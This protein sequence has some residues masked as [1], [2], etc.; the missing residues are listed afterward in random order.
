M[1][2]RAPRVADFER[3]A[4]FYG[5]DRARFVGGPLTPERAWRQLAAEAGHW[6]LRGYGRWALEEK[7]GGAF[8]GLVGLWFPDGF[9]DPE[10]G[11]DLMDGAEGRG[12]ATEAALAARA[13]AYDTL[14]WTTAIS[15][16]AKGNEGSCRV[17]ARLGA[18]YERTMDHAA[19]GK[20]EIWRHPAPGAA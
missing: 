12:Y 17:A 9:P 5:S 15:L 4:A 19:F 14:G 13:H 7:D 3:V 11:W 8:V 10:L 16:I 2:L 20:V 1:I 18:T 6:V